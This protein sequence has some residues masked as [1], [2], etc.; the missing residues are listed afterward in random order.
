MS[1]IF[2]VYLISQFLIIGISVAGTMIYRRRRRRSRKFQAP[3][4]FHRTDEIFVDPTTGVIQQ[5]WYNEQ[6]GE[7]LYETVPLNRK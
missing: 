5:V 1:T 3:P 7:R 4:G 6:S 2:I